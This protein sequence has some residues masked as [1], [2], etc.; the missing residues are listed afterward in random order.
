[1][2]AVLQHAQDAAER[3]FS[4]PGQILDV[5]GKVRD[6]FTGT[7]EIPSLSR[8]AKGNPTIS[9]REDIGEFSELPILDA[10]DPGDLR[11]HLQGLLARRIQGAVTGEEDDPD[12]LDALNEKDYSGDGEVRIPKVRSDRPVVLNGSYWL[13]SHRPEDLPGRLPNSLRRTQVP[14]QGTYTDT[15][16]E[17]ALKTWMAHFWKRPDAS[18]PEEFPSKDEGLPTEDSGE[19]STSPDWRKSR[20]TG[21]P[22]GDEMRNLEDQ[23]AEN[24]VARQAAEKA[25]RE[26]ELS[27]K[28]AGFAENLHLARPRPEY[29]GLPGYDEWDA[30]QKKRKERKTSETTLSEGEAEKD[31]EDIARLKELGSQLKELHAMRKKAPTGHSVE[32]LRPDGT[33][34]FKHKQY[35]DEERS[36]PEFHKQIRANAHLLKT[37]QAP[38]PETDESGDPVPEGSKIVSYQLHTGKLGTYDEAVSNFTTSRAAASVV[39]KSKE[40][41]K[42]TRVAAHETRKKEA[43]RAKVAIGVSLVYRTKDG[44]LKVHL[45][46][47]DE[48]TP[49]AST[50]KLTDPE[51]Q[52]L[53]YRRAHVLARQGHHPD[54]WP[55]ELP[56]GAE[57][58][59]GRVHTLHEYDSHESLDFAHEEFKNYARWKYKGEGPRDAP[60]ISTGDREN[61][62]QIP[63]ARGRT[64]A[65]HPSRGADHHADAQAQLE[66]GRAAAQKQGQ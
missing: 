39:A 41:A 48:I 37:G 29:E 49:G 34:V 25:R 8:N 46:P 35:T 21:T 22:L 50:T 57:F 32:I 12:F 63:T 44:G 9:G 11:S 5:L 42:A 33:T 7:G 51:T 52:K 28:R 24:E 18:K 13:G 61:M 26:K 4:S 64:P 36:D 27:E 54:N 20:L 3:L 10:S 1:M 43:M 58:L 38:L 59:E 23:E 55:E 14:G 6:K 17:E 62:P 2:S 56:E 47:V 16:D 31:K 40:E 53:A 15:G 66:Q 60:P 30:L 45:A 65:A 19:A